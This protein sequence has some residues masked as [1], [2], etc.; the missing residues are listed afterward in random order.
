MT[1]TLARSPFTGHQPKIRSSP[2]AHFATMRPVHPPSRLQ[3]LCTG[4]APQAST[5]PSQAHFPTTLAAATSSARLE[6][7]VSCPISPRPPNAIRVLSATT[8]TLLGLARAFRAQEARACLPSERAALIA[9]FL[10]GPA[11]FK[12]SPVRPSAAHALQGRSRRRTRPTPAQ[13]AQVAASVQMPA[14]QAASYFSLALL[15][16]TM[17]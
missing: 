12:T 10:V 13:R 1:T 7:L 6:H 14:H 16:H 8:A 9:A 15:G 3:R 4:N 5:C 11:V 2:T 17:K